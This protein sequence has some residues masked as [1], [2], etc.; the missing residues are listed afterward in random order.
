MKHR[1]AAAIVFCILMLV[2]LFTACGERR[3]S[4]PAPTA[5]PPAAPAGG[6]SETSGSKNTAVPSAAIA[7]S[8]LPSPLPSS[9]PASPAEPDDPPAEPDASRSDTLA[10]GCSPFSGKFSPFFSETASDADACA[11]TQVPLLTLDRAGAVVQKGIEGEDREYNGITYTYYGPADLTITENDDGTVYYDFVLREDLVFSDGVP[12]TVDDVIFSLYVFFDPSYDGSAAVC[13]LPIEGKKEY[14]AGM[15]TLLNLIYKAGRDNSDHSFFSAEQQADFWAKYD[16]AAVSL[17]REITDYCLEFNGD[18]GVVDVSGAASLWGFEIP[19]GGTLE[20]FAEALEAAYG[21]DI[22]GMI[23]IENAGSTVEELFPDLEEY[24]SVCITTGESAPIISG[25]RKT[26][27]YSLR[28]ILLKDDGNAA[29]A[30]AIPVAPLHYYGDLNLYDYDSDRFGFP[31][32]DLSLVRSR[33]GRPV[34]AGPYRFLQFSDGVVSYEAN[35]DYFLG[36]PETG[37][38]EYVQCNADVDELSGIV[39]GVID[40]AEPAFSAEKA[41]F[42]IRANGNG[43]MNGPVFTTETVKKPDG[44]LI[45]MNAVIFSTERVDVDSIAPDITTFYGWTAEIQNLRMN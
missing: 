42:I 10:V 5:V 43:S 20:D 32:G 7:P 16:A 36:V 25:I 2:A 18:Y 38:L 41:E 13:S 35:E 29:A 22:A 44:S 19:A 4:A 31:K 12:M 30:L 17:A 27:D 24:S 6:G 11:I 28:L 39:T 14:R 3:S 45:G 9:Q 23:S 1:K 37:R 26:G 34:G 40:V 21:S 33:T 15:D 8:P